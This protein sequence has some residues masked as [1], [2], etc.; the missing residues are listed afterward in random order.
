MQHDFTGAYLAEYRFGVTDGEVLD[1]IRFHT[2]G[3]ENMSPLGKLIFL[4]D[5]LESER[6]FEGVELLRGAFMEDLDKCF[7]LALEHQIAYLRQSG[8]NIYPLTERAYLS[9]KS[10]R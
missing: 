4:A 3:R 8:K 5:M 10:V 9:E 1:A 2:S 7:L 6:K